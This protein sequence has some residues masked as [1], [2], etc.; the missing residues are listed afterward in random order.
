MS[1]PIITQDVR[2]TKEFVFKQLHAQHGTWPPAS[3]VLDGSGKMKA[4]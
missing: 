1:A 2:V 4:A 3:V